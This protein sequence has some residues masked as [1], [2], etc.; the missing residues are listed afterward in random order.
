M[1]NDFFQ[2][3]ERLASLVSD[4][5]IADIERGIDLQKRFGGKPERAL[6]GIEPF[7]LY[8]RAFLIN[9]VNVEFE[10]LAINE[11]L[12]IVV[13]HFHASNDG[14]LEV[15]REEV[16]DLNEGLSNRLSKVLG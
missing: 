7:P 3:L 15:P 9:V 10:E 2:A 1:W 16:C 13:L 12:S 4:V 5:P 8:L 11:I 6:E 14:Y